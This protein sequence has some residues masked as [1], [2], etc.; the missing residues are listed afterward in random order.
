MS[1]NTTKSNDSFPLDGESVM[2]KWLFTILTQVLT[3]ASP[4]IL[5]DLRV[6]IQGMVE[7]AEATINPWDNIFVGMLQMI[8]GKPGSKISDLNDYR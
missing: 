3:M 4:Q 1:E 7:K 5:E 6:M 2:N 8:V